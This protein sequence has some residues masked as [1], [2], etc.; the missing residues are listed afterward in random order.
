MM[1]F[2][3]NY[4]SLEREVDHLVFNLFSRGKSYIDEKDVMVAIKAM[5]GSDISRND[6]INMIKEADIEGK[7][8]L[9]RSEFRQLVVTVHK[10][11]Y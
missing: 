1:A 2:S 10:P 11:G 9:E 8:H 7:G 4:D 5:T 3:Q 6:A